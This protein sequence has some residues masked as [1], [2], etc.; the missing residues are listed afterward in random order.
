LLHLN[1]SFKHS[2]TNVAT[3]SIIKTPISYVFDS[4]W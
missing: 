1:P 3:L 4:A 2:A